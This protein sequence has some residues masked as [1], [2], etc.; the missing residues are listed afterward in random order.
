MIQM[1][2]NISLPTPGILSTDS[3]KITISDKNKQFDELNSPPVENDDNS[4]DNNDYKE[5]TTIINPNSKNNKNQQVEFKHI[6]L[7]DWQESDLNNDSER[8]YYVASYYNKKGNRMLLI[9]TAIQFSMLLLSLSGSYISSFGNFTD[10]TRSVLMSTLNVTTAVL[11][12]IYTFFSFS[13][14]GQIYKDSSTLLF[15][16]IEK[17]KIAITTL[18]NDKEYE[19]IKRSL[20]EALL[21]CDTEC[22]REKYNKNIYIPVYRNEILNNFIR[23]VDT[24]NNNTNIKLINVKKDHLDKTTSEYIEMYSN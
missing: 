24:S 12:G 2:T 1:R 6:Y 13:K 14:K 19:E 7:E 22:I 9:G 15:H 11:S 3:H 5:P 16:K 21:K 10:F 8:A 23:S 4:E 17:I 20:T 18:K